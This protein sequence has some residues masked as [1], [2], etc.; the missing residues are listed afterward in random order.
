MKI[1]LTLATLMT[2]GSAHASYM[3]THC[4]N[5]DTSIHWETGHNSNTLTYNVSRDNAP[6]IV[7]F[8][9]LDI[10]LPETNVIRED[11][12]TQCG[13]YTTTKVYAGTAVITPAATS[14]NALDF[15][16]GEKKIT[17][18]VICTAVVS[19]SGYCPPL[20]EKN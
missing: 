9:D 13:L 20:P 16:E 2:I 17:T 19:S 18:E 4:S 15:L 1:F 14:P 5:S 12:H 7:P 3:A 6:F 10:N 8:Y 11:V